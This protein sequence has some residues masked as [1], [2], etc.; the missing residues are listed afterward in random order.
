M[1]HTIYNSICFI[2]LLK[3]PCIFDLPAHFAST[4]SI[5]SCDPF[6][7]NKAKKLGRNSNKSQQA[8]DVIQFSLLN[9]ASIP[10]RQSFPSLQV[11]YLFLSSKVAARNFIVFLL[12]GVSRYKNIDESLSISIDDVQILYTT[13]E[14]KLINLICSSFY[15]GYNTY[16]VRTYQFSVGLKGVFYK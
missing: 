10:Q 3:N 15:I 7:I 11:F 2:H 6:Q 12:N 5:Y 16:M 8:T 13:V 9:I 14:N 1:P 4:T